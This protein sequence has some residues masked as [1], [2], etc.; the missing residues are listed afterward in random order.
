MTMFR[1]IQHSPNDKIAVVRTPVVSGST[2]AFIFKD[3]LE[4]YNALTERYEPEAVDML[5]EDLDFFGEANFS[6]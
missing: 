1:A 2:N 5:M 6:V 4:M 3:S